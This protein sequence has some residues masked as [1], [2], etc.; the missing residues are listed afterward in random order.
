MVAIIDRMVAAG[1]ALGR[2]ALVASAVGR[3][4]HRQSAKEDAQML[5]RRGTGDELDDL[6]EWF[7]AHVENCR[8]EAP[9]RAVRGLYAD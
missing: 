4:T 1:K 2:A 9:R 8:N 7:G 6:V 3:E 5:S